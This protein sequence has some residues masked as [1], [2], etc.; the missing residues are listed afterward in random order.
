[1][2]YPL[3]CHRFLY[4]SHLI[5]LPCEEYRAKTCSIDKL[6]KW[7][8]CGVDVSTEVAYMVDCPLMERIMM[9]LVYE[10]SLVCQDY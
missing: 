3:N 4:N 8:K 1:M 5:K 10:L 6:L 9:I 2:L 7:K